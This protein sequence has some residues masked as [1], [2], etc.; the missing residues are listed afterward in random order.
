MGGVVRATGHERGSASMPA[1]SNGSGKDIK[2]YEYFRIR[3][4]ERAAEL[5]DL[6]T[7]EHPRRTLAELANGLNV[8]RST[9]HRLVLTL[10]KLRYLRRDP[11]GNT[12]GLGL[13]PLILGTVALNGLEFRKVVR[14]HL[15]RLN[16][17]TGQ[18]VHLAV[19]DDGDVVYVDKIEKE[20]LIRLYSEVGRRAPAHCTALGRVL[21]ASL[22]RATVRDILSRRP[23]R[24][25]TPRTLTDVE[26]LLRCI[27]RAGQEG[28]SLDLGEHEHLVQCVAAA[29]RDHSGAVAAAMSLTV[30][31]PELTTE[32][33]DRY[34]AAVRTSAAEASADLGYVRPAGERGEG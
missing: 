4:V 31:A 30:I 32:E 8:H 10:E 11:A 21:L 16:L 22:P 27:E 6:F 14:P 20:S 29:V 26:G 17:T 9:V 2:D 12:Y 34:L 24:R 19:L 1:V 23:L 3:A 7:L 5:L 25:Y 33:L 13:K 28:Y 15:E 18:T